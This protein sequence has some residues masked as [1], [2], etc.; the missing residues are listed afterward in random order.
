MISDLNRE[1]HGRAPSGLE[2]IGEDGAERL[3]ELIAAAK[4]NQAEALD[5]ATADSLR[6]L[7]PVLRT[8]L[9]KM[10]FK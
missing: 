8:P 6:F 5:V 2:P 3:A 9:R 1:L 7:P 10:L 4:R